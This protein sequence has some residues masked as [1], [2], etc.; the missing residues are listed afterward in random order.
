RLAEVEA[1]LEREKLTAEDRFR[2]LMNAAPVMMWLSGP[3]AMCIFFNRLWLE[4]RG[5]RMEDEIGN[6]WTDGIHPDDRELCLEAYLKAFSAR[7]PFRV[8]YRLQKATGDF[9]WVEDTG[10]PRF[11]GGN[12]TGFM[13]AAVDVS[14]R[15]RRAFM[16]DEQSVRMVFALTERE[17]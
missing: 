5:R 10:T 16:P 17:R 1:A 2:D 8:Q 3:D 11:E 6:G 4:F 7:Q 14:D 12:F 9:G 13:G 15:R